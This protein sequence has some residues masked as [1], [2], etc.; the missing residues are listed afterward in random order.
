LDGHIELERLEDIYDDLEIFATTLTIVDSHYVDETVPKKLIY[1][2]LKGLLASLDPYSQFL[3]PESHKDIQVETEGKFGG[4][5]IEVSVKDGVL[6]VISPISRTPAAKAGMKPGDRIAKI[7]SKSTRGLS[8]DDCVKL[9]RGK[10]GSIVN[11]TIVREDES[12]MLDIAITRDI[13]KVESIEYAT[14]IN[15]G[16]GYIRISEFQEQTPTDF[17]KELINLER[18]GLEGLIIDLRN[19]P[20]GLFPEAI[21]V[22]EL[23]VP[24]GQL[25]VSTRGRLIDQNAEYVSKGPLEKKSYPIVILINKGSASAS[26][27]MAGAL[28]DHQLAVILGEQSFGKGSVQTVIPMRDG[29]ALRLTTSKYYTPNGIAIHGIGLAPD[30]LVK[31]QDLYEVDKVKHQA[32][33]SKPVQDFFNKFDAS[34]LQKPLDEE[35]MELIAADNQVQRAMDLIQGLKVY[36]TK[37]V[38]VD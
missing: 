2:A 12:R 31:Y 19:N 36:S 20:G 1:G 34:G 13:V 37:S 27:V 18:T 5:G 11:L 14:F 16:I 24:Q 25:I 15:K 3:T 17:E 10:P 6:T 9:L 28:Q 21:R 30:V 29:S 8:L 35:L 26:E 32:N 38:I 4:I 23:F 7:D 22:A 33:K